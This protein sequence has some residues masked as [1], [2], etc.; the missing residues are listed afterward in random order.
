MASPL[1]R[2]DLPDCGGAAFRGSCEAEFGDFGLGDV[3]IRW[4]TVGSTASLGAVL[5]CGLTPAAMCCRRVRGSGR[6]G[7]G[8]ILTASPWFFSVSLRVSVVI[9][10]WLRLRRAVLL[11]VRICARRADSREAEH[12]VFGL[13]GDPICWSTVGSTDRVEGGLAASLSN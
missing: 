13:G 1:A 2:G 8:H 3:P 7:V 5:I 4:K 6:G 12:G 9:L 11:T 10:F